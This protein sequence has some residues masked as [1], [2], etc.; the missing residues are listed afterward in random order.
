MKSRMM[1][2]MSIPIG[3]LL[4]N[5]CKKQELPTAGLDSGANADIIV[6]SDNEAAA[7][8]RKPSTGCACP[9]ELIL[10]SREED[11]SSTQ[12]KVL[13][14]FKQDSVPDQVGVKGTG[15]L[16]GVNGKHDRWKSKGKYNSLEQI[17]VLY[18]KGQAVKECPYSVSGELIVSTPPV[19]PPTATPSAQIE[20]FQVM[21]VAGGANTSWTS[22]DEVSL[23]FYV[24]DRMVSG[25]VFEPIS[26]QSA[27]G[28]GTY[29]FYDDITDPGTYTYRVRAVFFD[30]TEKLFPGST[31][32]IN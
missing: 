23:D 27:A 15:D 22:T 3:L 2:L 25:G 1:I 19:D 9:Q 5:G 18:I 20:N 28:S 29:Y 31:V 24:V 30:G 7:L 32:T 10:A 16:E 17:L 11:L 13:A 26:G 14:F 6:N 21:S 8:K 12:R 4:L